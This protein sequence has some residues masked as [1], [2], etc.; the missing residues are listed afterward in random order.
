M[1]GQGMAMSQTLASAPRPIR[2][3][4]LYFSF[5]F[6]DDVDEALVGVSSQSNDADATSSL[7]AL[8]AT[9]QESEHFSSLISR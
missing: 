8:V 6:A 4:E 1:G 9:D 7:G 5:F 2:F 3:I